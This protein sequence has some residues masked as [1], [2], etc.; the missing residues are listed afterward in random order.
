VTPVSDLNITE[1]TRASWYPIQQQVTSY[2]SEEQLNCVVATYDAGK[3]GFFQLPPGFVGEVLSVYNSFAG[4]S[5]T[6][7]DNGKPINR[8][9]ASVRN[10]NEPSK[11]LVAPCFLPTFFGGKYWVIALGS[12][13]EG[14]YEWAL[15]SGGSPTQQ[16]S[17][18]CTTN[19][20]YFDSGLWIFSRTPMLPEA[21]L[22]EARNVLTQ[23][24]YTLQLLKDVRQTNCTY[25]KQYI[26]A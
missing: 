25:E 4:G 15:I 13:S 17:D 12:D 20:G 9:C 19:T 7:D 22:A 14:R 10:D 11:L 6:L 2:Q 16:Y 3:S 8:L 18:G 21:K 26:K 24:G 23:K 1:F 5:P